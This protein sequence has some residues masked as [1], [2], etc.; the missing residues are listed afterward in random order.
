[1]SGVLIGTSFVVKKKGLLR[2]QSKSG[3]VA[4]EGHAYLKDWMWW[5]GVSCSRRWTGGRRG[6][7]GREREEGE[8]SFEADLVFF[9]VGFGLLLCCVVGDLD[10]HDD[11]RRDL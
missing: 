10:D 6:E 5:L 1:M 9:L 8:S 4:G 3:A 7:G 2:A 11:R